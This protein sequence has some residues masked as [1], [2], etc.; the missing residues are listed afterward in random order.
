MKSKSTIAEITL[1]LSP[2]IAFLY[3]YINLFHAS[4]S[5]IIPHFFLIF[6]LWQSIVAL[7]VLTWRASKIL[8]HPRRR[9]LSSALTAV[10]PLALSLIYTTIVI[11]LFSWGRVITWPL[12]ASYTGKL[13]I[14]TESL[15]LPKTTILAASILF[16]CATAVACTLSYIATQR[17][18][19]QSLSDKISITGIVT[20]I[21]LS[22]ALAL[23]TKL[24]LSNIGG[25]HPQE[26]I[27]IAFFASGTTLLQSHNLASTPS[28]DQNEIQ[29]SS[30]YT[31]STSHKKRNLILIIGDALR[32]DHM[33]IYGY[34]RKTTPNL[35]KTSKTYQT[36]VF[37][38]MKAVC[39][40]SACGLLATASSRPLHLMPSRP[41]TLSEIM[42][43]NG[44]ITRLIL[45]GDHTNFYSLKEMY[46][47]TDI[48]L[49]GTNQK[50]HYINDDLLIL[51]F[52]KDIPQDD[53][54]K[55][56]FFQF[57]LMSTHGLG[58][59]QKI[60]E[61]FLPA[62]N[63]YGWQAQKKIRIASSAEDAQK[64][65]NY[66]DNGVLQFDAITKEI[67]E[68]LEQKG[69]LENSTIVLTADHGEM[70]GEHNFFGHQ[71]STYEEVLNIPF[72]IQRRGYTEKGLPPWPIASQI[73]IAPTILKEL[74]IPAP[75]TWKGIALQ[76]PP[77]DRFIHFQQASEAGIYLYKTQEPPVKYTKD[78]STKEETLI[79]LEEASKE[80]TKAA[81]LKDRELTNKLQE[82]I[83]KSGLS[84]Q[85]GAP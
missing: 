20:I 23:A 41:L 35:I 73:D 12:F 37:H 81:K 80:G 71:R 52:L 30:K 51:E 63:Y 40:E 6:I 49:D 36:L 8:S 11:G 45:S 18:W 64:A 54:K 19:C 75:T 38:G 60:N 28:I 26:P 42:V 82:E 74:D 10:P 79:T 61:K 53:K 14:F 50:A 43:R 69:Y 27:G 5:V 31:P 13:S 70:L 32:P 25:L 66:Y 65:T 9:L 78:L 7:R 72:I 67:L 84:E 44:Y 22:I 4:K 62:S 47:R 83:M 57:H 59:R 15:N 77:E 55:P 2:S 39:A 85:N 16:I 56:A 46:G 34:P 3:I 1:W 58:L 76:N 68:L 29:E 24:Y 33:S 21:P 17:D 48:Y